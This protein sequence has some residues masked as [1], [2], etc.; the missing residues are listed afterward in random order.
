[1]KTC[2]N[3][4]TSLD[5][6]ALFCHHCGYSFVAQGAAP[7][8]GQPEEPQQP[9]Q[10]RQPYQAQLPYQQDQPYQAAPVN[11]YDHTDEFDPQEVA[12]NKLYALLLYLTGPIGIIIALLANHDSP[13]LQFHIRQVIKLMVS[14]IICC[15]LFVIPFLGWAAGA[16][17]MVI[18]AICWIITFVRVCRN[19]SVEPPVVRGIGFL[20]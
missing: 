12:E 20:N 1:M 13:Y 10:P 6:N 19:K 5:D 17:L 18:I 7:E 8:T 15:V 4:Q 9:D 3:C 16:V 14:E 11:P 2:P